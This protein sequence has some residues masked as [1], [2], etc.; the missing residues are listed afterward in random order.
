MEEAERARKILRG[1][2][3][4]TTSEQPSAELDA[5]HKRVASYRPELYPFVPAVTPQVAS[6]YGWSCIAHDT[7]RCEDCAI[8]MGVQPLLL[9]LLV[10]GHKEGCLWRSHRVDPYTT[11]AP[12]AHSLVVNLHANLATLSSSALCGPVSGMPPSLA[13]ALGSSEHRALLAVCGWH[14][15]SKEDDAVLLLQCRHCCRTCAADA[16]FDPVSNHRLYCMFRSSRSRAIRL[17]RALPPDGS[18]ELPSYV[19]RDAAV[20]L[21]VW[22]AGLVLGLPDADPIA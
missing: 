13:A 1:L 11:L 9:Q 16:S 4:A 17:A 22:I 14:A 18:G 8:E 5:W 19:E 21:Y 15:V 3:V 2:P 12:G 10:A 20:P 7:L 6:L